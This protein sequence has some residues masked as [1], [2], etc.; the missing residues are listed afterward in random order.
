MADPRRGFGQEGESLAAAFLRRRG[1]KIL[2]TNFATPAGELDVVCEDGACV[3][4]VE[5][6]TRRSK[7]FGYPEEAITPEKRRHLARAANRFLAFYAW[8]S[9]PFRFD[10]VAILHRDG[11]EP[12]IAHYEGID[13][14]ESF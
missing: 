10:A 1:F 5:V 8:E 7:D 3:V 6:K 13:M 4:F 2:A 11:T 9:R 12:E 14:P